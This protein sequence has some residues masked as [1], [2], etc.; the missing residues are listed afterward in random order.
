[1]RDDEGSPYLPDLKNAEILRAVYPEG[2]YKDPSASPQDDSDRAQN[3]STEAVFPRPA[4]PCER[5][6]PPFDSVGGDWLEGADG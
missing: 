1:M 2:N 3:D 4:N 5:S 6:L